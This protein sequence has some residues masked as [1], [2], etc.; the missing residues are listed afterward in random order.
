MVYCLQILKKGATGPNDVFEDRNG[1]LKILNDNKF[2]YE[3]IKNIGD[4]FSL[5]D[6][7]VDIKKYPVC[8]ASHAAAD[9]INSILKSKK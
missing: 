9:G 5:L 1:I 4:D 2:N 8:Y 3:F 7:G 6:P